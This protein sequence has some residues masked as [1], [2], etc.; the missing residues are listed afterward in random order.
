MKEI[1][2]QAAPE[3]IPVVTGF[4]NA[5]L[6]S[7]NCPRGSRI[8]IDIAV[9]EIFGNIAKYAYQPEKG[10]ATVKIEARDHPLRVFITFIDHGMQY[11]PLSAVDPNIKLTARQRRAGGLGIF[12]IKK[13]MDD[14][15]Y[16]Y[17]NGENILTICKVLGA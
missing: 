11:N 3:N 8:Q 2:V 9:D 5:E 13:T 7:L 16:D 12:M 17:R 14:V 15:A 4:V 10:P 6:A 1:T